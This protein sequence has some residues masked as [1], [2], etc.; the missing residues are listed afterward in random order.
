MTYLVRALVISLTYLVASLAAGCAFSLWLFFV[1]R[2]S[3]AELLYVPGSR[4]L[5]GLAASI[6]VSSELVAVFSLGA[7]LPAIVYSEKKHV[8]S[9]WP[10]C[11]GGA[12]IGLFGFA[13]Y[14]LA[15]ALP[16]STQ[17]LLK[18]FEFPAWGNWLATTLSGFVG[19][20]VYWLVAGRHAGSRSVGVPSRLR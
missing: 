4:D 19:G 7:A 6:V 10:Y 1:V 12:L 13:L 2:F 8:R 15:Q 16:G 14:Y 18:S 5:I 17:I 9:F 20:T 11:Y 3:S